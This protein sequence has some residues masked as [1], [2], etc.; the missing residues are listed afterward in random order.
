MW[1]DCH[2]FMGESGETRMQNGRDDGADDR[3]CQVQPSIA[4]IGGRDHRAKR[5][6]RVEGGAG[7]RPADD[8]VEG[9]SHADCQRSEAFGAARNR[10]A[11]YHRDQEKRDH[12]LDYEAGYG[13]D[14]K[15]CGAQ[16]Q[17]VRERRPLPSPTK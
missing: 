15:R 2:S 3:S 1:L 10:C 5:P 7:E 12:G 14:R 4:K 16:S 9:Q 11:E 13:R 17:V 8:D 6:R